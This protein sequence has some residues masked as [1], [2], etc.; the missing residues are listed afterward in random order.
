M[1]PNATKDPYKTL[2]VY[3]LDP[4]IDEKKL[5]KE[6][7]F[8]GEIRKVR[9]V[10]DMNGKSRGYGFIEFKHGSHFKYAKNQKEKKIM[11]CVVLIDYE[12]GRIEKGWKP[13]RLGGGRGDNRGMPK[14]LVD[15]LEDIGKKYPDLIKEKGEI[16]DSQWLR[17]KKHRSHDKNDNG[18]NH[19]HK[20][21]SNDKEKDNKN[22]EENH[23]ENNPKRHKNNHNHDFEDDDKTDKEDNGWSNEK[24]PKKEYEVGEI[25]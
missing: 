7:E 3:K 5:Q 13:R 22:D 21:K 2:F 24:S 14:W 17:N 11:S 19:R 18:N 9:V 20:D 12:R 10:R 25:V 16:S 23:H 6:F 4:K 15:Q 1:N 8:Y